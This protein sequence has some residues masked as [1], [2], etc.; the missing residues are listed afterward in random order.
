[1]G[2]PPNTPTF[3][4]IFHFQPT[5]YIG[6]PPF[7]QPPD[8]AQNVTGATLGAPNSARDV[9]NT[10]C[11]VILLKQPN[12]SSGQQPQE[13][14]SLRVLAGRRAIVWRSSTGVGKRELLDQGS[15]PLA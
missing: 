14:L 2:L 4:R 13:M 6:N 1:M 9:S 10:G 12:F 7:Q 15:M 8:I 5:S 3:N 11:R